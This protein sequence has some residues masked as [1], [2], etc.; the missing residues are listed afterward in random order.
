MDYNNLD[1]GAIQMYLLLLLLALCAVVCF[2]GLYYSYYKSIIG[3]PTFFDGMHTIMHDNITEYPKV[4]NTLNRFNL[5]PEVRAL[6]V[7]YSMFLSC[8]STGFS[9]NL[10]DAFIMRFDF[11]LKKY[12][13]KHNFYSLLIETSSLSISNDA[14][15]N[16]LNAVRSF[17]CST[18]VGIPVGR[19]TI[20][21]LYGHLNQ[22]F[23]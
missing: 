22:R 8:S 4:I 12:S 20:L 23:S 2:Q 9:G 16:C 5:Y 3:A 17:H 1:C 19:Y 11:P 13:E 14:F 6:W 7:I 15:S 10:L 18:D 21:L